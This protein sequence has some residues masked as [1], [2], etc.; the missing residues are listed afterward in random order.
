LLLLSGFAKNE[1]E[2]I[3]DAARNAYKKLVPMLVQHYLSG[4]KK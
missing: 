3:G 2:N 4:G 1:M